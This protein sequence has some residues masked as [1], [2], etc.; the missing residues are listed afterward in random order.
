MRRSPIDGGSSFILKPRS[1][2]SFHRPC[3]GT[4]AC[5]VYDEQRIV[6]ISVRRCDGHAE[7]SLVVVS[8]VE[9]L[10]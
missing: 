8:R 4:V 10:P 6:G 1:G 2:G 7:K 9:S 3:D 5:A